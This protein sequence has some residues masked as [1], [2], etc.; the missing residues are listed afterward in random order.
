MPKWLLEY[1]SWCIYVCVL[2]WMHRQFPEEP[3]P[4]LFQVNLISAASHTILMCDF[5]SILFQQV[6]FPSRTGIW[7]LLINIISISQQD[8]EKRKLFVLVQIFFIKWLMVIPMLRPFKCCYPFWFK[9]LFNG[10]KSVLQSNTKS[11]MIMIEQVLS[12]FSSYSKIY[13]PLR[14]IK[15]KLWNGN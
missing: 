8:L 13:S 9:T 6:P 3:E 2:I 15:R 7:I 14:F 10:L 5:L 12:V 11:I 4:P 1:A